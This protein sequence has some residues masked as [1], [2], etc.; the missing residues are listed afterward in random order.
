[1]QKLGTAR[2]TAHAIQ[3][4]NSFVFL[5]YMYLWTLF[6]V[7][8]DCILIGDYAHSIGIVSGYQN[9]AHERVVS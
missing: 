1:M 9:A 2:Y 3:H 5:L 6:C 4:L 8:G 7:H